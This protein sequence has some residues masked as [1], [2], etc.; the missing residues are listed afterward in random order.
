MFIS[1]VIHSLACPY[2]PMD[3]DHNA[4]RN[5]GPYIMHAVNNIHWQSFGSF[6]HLTRCTGFCIYYHK[7]TSLS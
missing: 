6:Y 4:C 1:N 3:R 7:E 2:T 5:R